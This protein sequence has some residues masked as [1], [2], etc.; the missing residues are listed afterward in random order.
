MR[1][2]V[3]LVERLERTTKTTERVAALEAYFAQAPA[4]DAA[5]A[6][7]LL[8]GRRQ[9]RPVSS[10]LMRAWAAQH[11]GIADW[12]FD[13]CYSAVGDLGETI[14]LLVGQPP[15]RAHDDAAVP[16]SP[17]LAHWMAHIILP[18]RGLPPEQQAERVAQAW[19]GLS[20]T[21][22]FVVNKLIGGSFRLGVSQ[23]LV[24]R[25]LARVLGVA[26]PTLTQRLMGD[27]APSEA[28]FLQLK[29]GADQADTSRPY[30]FCLA[31]ALEGPPHDLGA[32]TEWLAE[33]KWDGIR[34]QVIVR[35]GQL[36][37]WSRGDELLTERFPDLAALGAL[38]PEGTALDGELVVR[39]GEA[40]QPRPFAELQRRIQRKALTPKLL[41]EL[42]AAV[43]AYDLLEWQGA[44]IRSWPL[45]ARRAQL[46]ALVG[47]GPPAPELALSPLVRFDTWGALADARAQARAR[48][49]EGLMLKRADSPY[50][51]GRRRGDWWKWKLDPYSADAVLLY[52]QRGTGRRAGLY[53]D[54]TFAVWDDR[55]GAE[56][57]LVPFAKAYSGLTDAEIAQVDAWVKAQPGE[58]FGPVRAVPPELVMELGFEGIQRSPRH[59]SG[60]AVR[61]PRILRWRH[62]KSAADADT[63]SALEA[64]LPVP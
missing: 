62:D 52:A 38:L 17:G 24:V 42:P 7:A 19:A 21:E 20:V 25:A 47:A 6:L 10:T 32:P 53:T 33:W 61:F 49:S 54:Y 39:G 63:L 46:E 29:A 57:R 55:P 27:W 58:R 56:R 43:L 5:W 64:L 16:S 8:T 48:G 45:S 34:C 28:F 51:V 40:G 2:F 41:A 30:P 59:K 9:R 15:T 37:L 60:L 36:H 31:H 12:L 4:G 44:D 22:A 23:G 1:R 26:E 35:G 13:E 3:E 14:A 18:L 11:A 50:G